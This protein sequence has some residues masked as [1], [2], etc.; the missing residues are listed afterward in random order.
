MYLLLASLLD[1]VSH[2][3]SGGYVLALAAICMLQYVAHVYGLSASRRDKK[4]FRQQID[5]LESQLSTMQRER[6]LGRF[7]NQ[8]LREFV[9]QADSQRAISLVLRRLVPNA[10]DGFA[11]FLRCDAERLFTDQARGLTRESQP[12]RMIDADLLRRIRAEKVLQLDLP[13]VRK[14]PVWEA[15]SGFDGRRCGNCF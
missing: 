10:D 3:V 8:M 7:E 14:S 12:D 2:A 15:L 5:G 11:C 9:S 1:F 6:Q 13:A 4:H